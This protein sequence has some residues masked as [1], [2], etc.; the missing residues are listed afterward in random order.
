MGEGIQESS[1]LQRTHLVIEATRG[2]ANAHDRC[3][4][5]DGARGA[6]HKPVF[7]GLVAAAQALERSAPQAQ[8]R[9]TYGEIAQSDQYDVGC[10]LQS[11]QR[12]ALIGSFPLRSWSKALAI[13]R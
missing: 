4:I 10:E 7:V 2:V 11:Q 6:D 8:K 13:R 9:L 5:D 12:L 3:P 1:F